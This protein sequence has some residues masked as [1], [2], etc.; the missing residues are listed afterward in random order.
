M[1]K[2]LKLKYL[3]T[4]FWV[5]AAAGLVYWNIGRSSAT[6]SFYTRNPG[7][8]W[9]GVVPEDP[10]VAGDEGISITGERHAIAAR[11]RDP[12]DWSTEIVFADR[13]ADN[14]AYFRFNDYS[15]IEWQDN[16]G[17]PADPDVPMP[18][19]AHYSAVRNGAIWLP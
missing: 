17:Q 5:V 6:K 7:A 3:V 10:T 15:E 8:A 12:V 19:G 9:V 2:I 11:T 16:A 13:R 4:V 14:I 18:P 1:K